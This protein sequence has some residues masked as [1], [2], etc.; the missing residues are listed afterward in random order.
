MV[1]VSKVEYQKPVESIKLKQQT[2]FCLRCGKN[3]TYNPNAPYCDVCYKSWAHFQNWNFT[4]K[5]CHKCGTV[6]ATSMSSPQCHSC[7][8]AWV[9]EKKAARM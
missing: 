2:A 1:I 9:V 5:Y 7:H 6:E 4:E 3:I 8:K